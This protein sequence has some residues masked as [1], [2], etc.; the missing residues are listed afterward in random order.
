MSSRFKHRELN[1]HQGGLV[2]Q[3][4]VDRFAPSSQD[5]SFYPFPKTFHAWDQR[6]IRG[7]KLKDVPHYE[8]ELAFWGGNLNSLTSKLPYLKDLGVTILYLNPIFKAFT[9]HKYDTMDYLSIDSIYGTQHEF[10][11]LISKAHELN[12]K[13]VLDGV[14]NHVSYYHPY[15]QEALRDVH[16][17]YRQWFVFGSEF[18]HGYRAWHNAASLPELNLHHV[19]V[20]HHIFNEVVSYY[21]T[22]GID[23]WRLDTGI[24]L[25]FT[26]LSML[27]ST[28]HKTRSDALIVG[29]INNYPDGWFPHVDGV[30]QLVIRDLILQLVRGTLDP[31]VASKMVSTYIND[32]GLDN[33]LK[34]W[35]LLENHDTAR[36]RFDLKDD[37]AYQL[38]KYVSITLPGTYHL[39]QGEELGLS[40][41]DDPEN[42]QPFPWDL[43]HDDHPPL[44]FHRHLLHLRSDL[45]ALRIGDYKPIISQHTLAFLRYT[46]ITSE[47]CVVVINPSLE[48]KVE[49]LMIPD[50]RLRGHLS[51]YDHITQTKIAE[52]FGIFLTLTI[53]AQTCL[54]LTPNVKPVDGYN[55]I[56]Y[57]NEE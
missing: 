4:F 37:K 10:V 49:T 13:V 34:S 25:G 44:Q 20:Q 12:M 33:L 45:R 56:K 36:I 32:A 54:I 35:L 21:L 29:E 53:P 3:V 57:Y 28:A 6:P 30:M 16:S 14:F 23:G 41:G 22:L 47:T 8:H 46:D 43:V 55:P 51:F 9:N 52:S 17:P 39:Y 38:A 24:E 7:Q 18:R 19:D 5:A 15:F 40:A 2:Y 48:S 31:I 26:Y 42:R 1:W 27:T 11:S 50:H